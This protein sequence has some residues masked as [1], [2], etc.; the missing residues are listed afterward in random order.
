[1]KIDRH[2]RAKIL[3]QAELQL[4]FSQGLQN[5]RDRAIFGICLYTACRINE[6]CTLRTAD[7]YDTKGLV[8]P[9]LIIRK[10]ATKGKLAT[11]TIPVLEDLR[12]R[13]EMYQPPD[14]HGFLFPGRHGREHLLADSASW[15]L[16]EACKRVRLEGVSTHSFRRTALTQMSDA[17]IPLRIIQEVSGHRTLDELQ[18]Y[19]EVRPEQVRGAVAALAMLSPVE[20]EAVYFGKSAFDDVE[21][22][23]EQQQLESPKPPP[24][25]Q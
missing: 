2:G 21:S 7:V 4:L 12:R 16:R 6:A 13:L 1:M 15:L 11:R 18:K 14:P 17:G 25:R 3:T 20:E 22:L 23:M 24:R 9:E 19:L 10:G 8:R 5:H